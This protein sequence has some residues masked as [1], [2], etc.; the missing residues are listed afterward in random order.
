MNTIGFSEAIMSKTYR[1]GVA[2][3]NARPRIGI[4]KTLTRQTRTTMAVADPHEALWIVSPN[5][6]VARL[7]GLPGN[8]RCESLDAAVL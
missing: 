2:G 5:S 4:W 1:I 7:P 8:D 6:M 3:L